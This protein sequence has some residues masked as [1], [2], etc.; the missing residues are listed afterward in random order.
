MRQSIFIFILNLLFFIDI[1][2]QDAFNS[3]FIQ[4]TYGIEQH[5]KRL[6][7]YSEK[8]ILLGMQPEKW[9][10]YHFNL[11]LNRK[12]KRINKFSFYSGVGINYEKATFLR[13]F[14]HLYFE[15][16]YDEI[17]RN[18]NKYEKVLIPLSFL[19]KFRIINQLYLDFD[20]RPIFIIYRRI[21]HTQ[22]NSEVFPYSEFV[23]KFDEINVKL[24]LNYFIGNFSFGFNARLGNYQKIDKIIFNKILKDPRTDQKW[25][26]YNPLQ[27]NF[28]VGYLW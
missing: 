18:L 26:F 8:E 19:T 14:D 11:S 16:D 24:G 7:D 2:G 9:G 17:L 15:N 23:L 12:L 5:D 4:S 6:F 22:N 25:E 27:F 13:P 1:E 10:T 3:W 20:L 28:T 21:D